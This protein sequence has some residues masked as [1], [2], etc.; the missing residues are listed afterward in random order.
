[1]KKS[2]VLPTVLGAIIIFLA[3]A[4][5]ALLIFMKNQPLQKRGV[6]PLV[7]VEAMEPDSSVWGLNFPNQYSTMQKTLSN[8]TR[9]VYGGSEPYSKLEADPRLVKLF[10]SY[11]FSIEYNE[12]RGHL[13]GLAGR[14]R[15]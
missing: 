14:A 7:E 12:D 3:V 9:T 13:N 4:V 2:W 15:H 6:T 1:M 8:N 11:G 10:A 5:I